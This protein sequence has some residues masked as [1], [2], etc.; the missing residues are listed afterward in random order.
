MASSHYYAARSKE[1]LESVCQSVSE[2]YSLP[3]FGFDSHE[4]WRYG[5]SRNGVIGFNV[6][7]ASDCR[8]IEK[9]MPECP[10]GV[11]FQIIVE[12]DCQPSDLLVALSKA[13]GVTPAKYLERETST[14]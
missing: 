8:T 4:S 11:N 9:W 12:A 3:E 14:G 10:K 5:W 2:H 7:K 6:T 13:L 1:A